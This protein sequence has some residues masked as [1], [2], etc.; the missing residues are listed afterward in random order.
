MAKAAKQAQ[1]AKTTTE[2]PK[3]EPHLRLVD[4]SDGDALRFLAQAING[5]GMASTEDIAAQMNVRDMFPRRV[6]GARFGWLRRLGYVDRDEDTGLWF[7][8]VEG[9][10]FYES[11]TVNA[12]DRQAIE[13][14]EEKSLGAVTSMLA[15]KMMSGTQLHHDAIR[16]QIH[17]G[18]LRRKAGLT[19]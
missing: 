10:A 12:R 9:E 4:I 19:R 11:L 13:R 15:A 5:D 7:F 14:L 16:R 18:Q 3:N 1:P 2:P 17:H 6:V 8:T